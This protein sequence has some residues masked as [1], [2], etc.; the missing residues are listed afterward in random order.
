MGSDK[1]FGY[2][3]DGA[4][5]SK[6]VYALPATRAILYRVKYDE[7]AQWSFVCRRCWDSVSQNNPF[8]VYGGTWKAK[9]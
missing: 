7:S 4:F 1:G 6:T 2:W 8:Y 3:S 9:K 5:S